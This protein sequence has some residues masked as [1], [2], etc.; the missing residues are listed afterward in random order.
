M[1]FISEPRFIVFYSSNSKFISVYRRLL[2]IQQYLLLPATPH[3]NSYIRH[4]FT[5][6]LPTELGITP[7]SLARKWLSRNINRYQT[8]FVGIRGASDV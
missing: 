2:S 6:Y 4:S 8:I 5:S 7:P 1:Q 3:I